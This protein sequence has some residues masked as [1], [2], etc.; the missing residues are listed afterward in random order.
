[1]LGQRGL[2][3]ARAHLDRVPIVM[4]AR[5]GRTIEVYDIAPATRGPALVQWLM[6]GAW[7]V[8]VAA[9]ICGSVVARRSHLTI[10]PLLTTVV[11]VIPTVAL[12]W[13][14]PR[15]RVPIDVAALVLA[16]IALDAAPR[17]LSEWRSTRRAAQ[18]CDSQL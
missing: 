1:M 3:Y 11:V 15:F 18:D 10:W 14:L 4:A 13:G 8:V 2:G 17:S 7:Y 16:A 5:V 6:T 12:T 9:A